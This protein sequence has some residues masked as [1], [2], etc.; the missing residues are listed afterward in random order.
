MDM[1]VPDTLAPARQLWLDQ[2]FAAKTAAMGGVVRRRVSD[3]EREIGRHTLE[4]EVRRRGYHLLQCDTHFVI[5][6]FNRP[7]VLIC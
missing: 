1:S 2:I 7:L 4:L 3:V 5:I 6:C